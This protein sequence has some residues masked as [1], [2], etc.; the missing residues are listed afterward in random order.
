MLLKT[1]Y[2]K[3]EE[4]KK[5]L[6][7]KAQEKWRDIQH[8]DGFHGQFGGWHENEACVFTLW[9][10]RNAYQSFM[11]GA[12][13][14]IYLN[15][16]QED[17]FL[18]CEIELFQTLYDITDTHLKDVVTEGS[19]VRVAICDVKGEKENHFLHKQETIWNKGMKNIK[20]ML[21]G[22]VGKSLQN[23]NRYIVLTY[24]QDGMA[25]QNYVEEIL[26]E[27]YKLANIHED[28]EDMRGKQVVCK[29]EWFV[30]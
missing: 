5:E 8:L 18:S 21:G 15:S 4:E 17:T 2:C 20:G 1:I 10:D 13:D 12:H 26:T 9:E 28:I 3:V 11:N 24:W 14:T 29:E 30:Y 25:H 23:E 19:F 7:S 27:L 6:F 16:N 22:I